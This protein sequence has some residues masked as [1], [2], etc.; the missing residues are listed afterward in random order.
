M[1]TNNDT[2]LTQWKKRLICIRFI[3]SVLV[4]DLKKDEGILK[5][6]R[7]I[8]PLKNNDIDKIITV[9]F[10]RGSSIIKL[11]ESK[12]NKDWTIDR[13][14]L[15]DLSIMIEAICESIAL[16][17]DKKIIIDQAIVTSKKYSESNSYKFI[18]SILDKIIK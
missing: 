7:E 2:K 4:L 18:N 17:I 13:I 6:Q 14:N 8:K 3:Y 15:V 11:I 10:M 1:K 16:P 12:L 9:F 5:F